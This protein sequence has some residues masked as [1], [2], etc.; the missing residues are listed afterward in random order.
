MLDSPEIAAQVEGAAALHQAEL[1][2]KNEARRTVAKALSASGGRRV[3]LLAAL[4]LARAGDTSRAQILADELSTALPK[5]TLLQKYWLPVIRASIE[6]S[7][8]NPSKAISLLQPTSYELSN[9][10]ILAGNLYP[11]YVRGQAYLGTHQGKEA[12]AEFQKFLDYAGIAANSPL[13]ALARLGLARAYLMQR[14]RER[15]TNAYR[16]FLN[17]WKDADPDIPILKQAKAEY[18]KHQ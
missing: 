1:G 12:A 18:A 2:L 10:P 17:L 7:H 9:T 15:S 3:K 14:E 8:Q 11:A 4:V 5:N 16:D 13:A 6:L